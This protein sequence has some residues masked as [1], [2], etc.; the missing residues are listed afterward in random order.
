[1]IPSA[2]L[3]IFTFII[4]LVGRYVKVNYT[5]NFVPKV[6]LVLKI[7]YLL[8]VLLAVGTFLLNY[9]FIMNKATAMAVIYLGIVHFIA[10]IIYTTLVALTIRQCTK[11]H[12]AVI[13]FHDFLVQYK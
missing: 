1:M 12:V 3:I 11:C 9:F 10:I 13:E 2:V 4:F 8:L 6:A 5:V 7:F